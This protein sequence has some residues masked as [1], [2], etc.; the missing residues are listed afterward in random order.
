M[1]ERFTEKAHRVIMFA[2]EESRRLGH[3]YVGTEQILLAL[4]GEGT[5][6][7]SKVLKSCGVNLKD[8]RNEVEKI[9]GRDF[10]L[11]DGEISFNSEAQQVFSLS[12]DESRHLGHNYIGTEHLLLGL[13]GLENTVAIKVLQELDIDLEEVRSGIFEML[14]NF[15]VQ[16]I[17]PIKK[18]ESSIDFLVGKKLRKLMRQFDRW[19][20]DLEDA[21]IEAKTIGDDRWID[22]L[23]DNLKKAIL[24][25]DRIKN[26]IYDEA[27]FFGNVESA[28]VKLPDSSQADRLGIKELLTQ[29]KI[30]IETD[31][32]LTF[33]D[34]EEALEQVISIAF[35]FLNI[36]DDR[37][38]RSVKTSLKILRGTIVELPQDSQLVVNCKQILPEISQIFD[39]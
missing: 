2:T 19:I 33:E 23:E 17:P 31:N 25:A 7:A 24:T 29:L 11:L 36:N 32:N 34:K 8:A 37:T 15:S 26:E 21:L 18:V 35:A 30:A 6:V 38:K 13:I 9:I 10:T 16:E 22:S 1:F 5:G 12:L 20:V 39:L 14:E 4:I 27:I 3:N 28:L